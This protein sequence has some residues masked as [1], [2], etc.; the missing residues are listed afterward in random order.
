M[1]TQSGEFKVMLKV[2]A[3]TLRHFLA[4]FSDIVHLLPPPPPAK[5]GKSTD[6][7]DP[8]ILIS[9]I[10]LLLLSLISLF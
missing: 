6:R 10:V 2:V 9:L 7:A 4:R 8:T 5:P 1:D 3:L